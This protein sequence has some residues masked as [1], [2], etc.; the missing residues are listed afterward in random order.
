[1]SGVR[2]SILQAANTVL[3]ASLM[4][5]SNPTAVQGT[6]ALPERSIHSFHRG[7]AVNVCVNDSSNLYEALPFIEFT[8]CKIAAS[9][10]YEQ[11]ISF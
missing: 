7:T 11:D 6:G 3:L 2:V 4:E 5:Q 10:I 9:I 1:M 8:A